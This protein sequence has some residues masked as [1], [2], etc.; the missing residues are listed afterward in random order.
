MQV[1]LPVLNASMEPSSPDG[2][3]AD[4]LDLAVVGRHQLGVATPTRARPGSRRPASVRIGMFSR[5]GSVEESRPVAASSGP[6]VNIGSGR[7]RHT[8]QTTVTVTRHRSDVAVGEQMLQRMPRLHQ[9]QRLQRV[10]PW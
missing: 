7:R 1:T 5:L 10:D 3:A 2:S 9:E 4:H 6:N 8:A